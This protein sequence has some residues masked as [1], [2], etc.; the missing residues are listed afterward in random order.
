MSDENDFYLDGRSFGDL[1]MTWQHACTLC[2]ANGD[3]YHRTVK[4]AH[5]IV[6]QTMLEWYDDEDMEITYLL[7]HAANVRRRLHIRGYTDER[8][9]DLWDR[10]YLKH[11]AMLE[12]MCRKTDTDLQLEIDAQKGL[13]FDGWLKR[14][15]DLGRDHWVRRGFFEF[16]LTD[17]FASLALELEYFKPEFVWTDLAS[18]GNEFDL[19]L[20][21][22][23][24]LR[25]LHQFEDE[26]QEF[27]RDTGTVLGSRLIDL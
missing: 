13:S 9:R 17:M 15:N 7:A 6:R 10:E 20:S 11:I 16:D 24:N 1:S 2:F 3:L 18:Y 26:H 8:C 4:T 5:P 27:V 25:R 14:A 22:H 23:Q 12:E 19:E 21:V